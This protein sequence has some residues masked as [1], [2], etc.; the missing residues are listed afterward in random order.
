MK[1]RSVLVIGGTKF[2]G[3]HF[4]ERLTVD[5]IFEPTLLNRGLSN[6]GLFPRLPKITCDRNNAADCERK[7]RGSTWDY[8][9]DFTGQTDHD[10]R[11]I[12]DHCRSDHYTFISSS[13][14][15]LATKDD[16][17]FEMARN[18]LWCEHVLGLRTDSLLVVRPAFVCGPHD[19]TDRF[20][21]IAGIW[22]WKETTT[23]VQPMVHVSLLVNMLHQCLYLNQTGTIRAGYELSDR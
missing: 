6:P 11:N 3:R 21:R 13:A 10:I 1:N 8:I 16:E 19:Y 18:K 9:V 2:I 17:H 15:D 7:L 22:V 14:V 23:M 20:E 4:T 5:D 12:T